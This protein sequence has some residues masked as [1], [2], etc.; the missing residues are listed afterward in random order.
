MH[1]AREL[2]AMGA[3]V[4]ILDADIYGPNIPR[5]LNIKNPVEDENGKIKPVIVDEMQVMSMGFLIPPDQALVWRGPMLHSALGQLLSDVLWEEADYMFID[6]PPGTGDVQ[7]SL[8][9]LAPMSGG[10]IVATPHPM[11]V[12]DALRGVNA[13]ERLSVPLLGIVE[14]MSGSVFGT[15]GARTLA[16]SRDLP[17]LGSV[18]LEEELAH[19]SAAGDDSRGKE[20]IRAIARKISAALSVRHITEKK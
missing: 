15:G 2:V 18:P 10:V 14:N 17:F 20:A 13:F 11:A 7:L 3:K 5:M 19:G 8:S 4:A 16:E 9:Q 6:M 12:D 1:L